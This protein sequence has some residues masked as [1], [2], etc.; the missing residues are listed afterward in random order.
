MFEIGSSQAGWML[1]AG[2]RWQGE[3]PPAKEQLS[4]LK[5]FRGLI[6]L[7]PLPTWLNKKNISIFKRR[8]SHGINTFFG[9]YQLLR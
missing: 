5:L 7:A 2:N 8:E 3:S 4:L 6:P 9:E 1:R